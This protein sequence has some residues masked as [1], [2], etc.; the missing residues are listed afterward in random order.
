MNDVPADLLTME[1]M[2]AEVQQ[3]LARLTARGPTDGRVTP[4]PDTRTVRYYIGLGLVDRPYLQ[5]RQA[6]YGRRHVLQLVAIK[7]L[8]NAGLRLE[9][10]QKRLYG[11]S[12]SE[13]EALVHAA[14]AAQPTSC[15]PVVMIWKEITLLPGVKLLVDHKW[16]GPVDRTALRER[17]ESVLAALADGERKGDAQ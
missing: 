16:K 5:G 1:Q 12:D 14:R 4:L 13:L 17:I 15:P 6:R 8:Q 7:L 11:R 9:E 2:L 3:E 10:I